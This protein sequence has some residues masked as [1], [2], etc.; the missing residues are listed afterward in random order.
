MTRDEEFL[1]FPEAFKRRYSNTQEDAHETLN[2]ILDA[3]DAEARVGLPS[4]NSGF[5]GPLNDLR[6]LTPVEQL[7]CGTLRNEIQ[8]TI[9][10]TLLIN[11]ERFRELN[12]GIKTQDCTR[13]ICLEDLLDDYF[14]SEVLNSFHCKKCKKSIQVV[15]TSRVLRAPNLLIIQLKRFNSFGAKISIPV[16]FNVM[17][18]LFMMQFFVLSLAVSC[19]LTALVRLNMGRYVHNVKELHLY[20]LSGVIQHLGN[21]ADYGHYNAVVRSFDGRSFYLL[22]DEQRHRISL[23]DLHNTQ[24]YILVYIRCNAFKS[25]EVSRSNVNDAQN[26]TPPKNRTVKRVSS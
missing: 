23:N 12:L 7:F 21:S 15:R 17:Y 19:H 14:G 5:D 13:R 20:D 22:D 2:H 3:L 24:A 18:V 1:L 9:C 25:P 8:C 6:L 10:S 11:Y 4:S 26:G 16:N